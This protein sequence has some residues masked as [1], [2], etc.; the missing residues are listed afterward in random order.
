[1]ISKTFI[2]RKNTTIVIAIIIV[3]VGLICM[4][5][6]PIAQL[7][8]IAPPVT[9]VRANYVGANS[10]TVEETVTT[11][12]EN[13]VNGTPGA[14]YIQSVSANDGSMSITVSFKLGTNPDIATL[15]V[16]NRVSLALPSTPDEV[17][18]VGV[19]VKKRSN[20]ML[21]VIAL[22]SPKGKHSR[23][24]LDNYM[25]IYL[26]PELARVSGVG[27]VNAFSQDYSMRIWLNPDKMAALGLTAGDIAR[28]ITEQNQQVPAGSVGAAPMRSTQAFEYT[29]SVKGRLATTEEFGNVVV[30]T[31]QNGSLVRLRDV[32]RIDLG[33]FTYAIEAKA[34]GKTG[35]GMAIY[36]APGANALDVND[37]V[38]AKLEEMSKR[39][40][41]DVK[42][43]VPFESTS[44]VK[45]SIEEV[46]ETFVEALI[47]VVIVVFVFLQ[48]WRATIIPILVIPISLIGTFI[49]FQLLGF[50]INTLTLF[51]FVLAIG[52]VVDDAI[53]VVEAVQHH[54]DANLMTPREATFKAMSEV[55]GPVIAIALIL[56]AVFVPVAFIP[57]VSGRLYQQFALTIAFS[58]LLSA[59][60]ALTL[61][62]ALT[63]ILLR[64]AHLTQ[65]ST[66]LNKIFFKFNEWFARVT[67]RYG[68]GVMFSIRKT[69]AV[70]VIMAVLFVAAFYLFKKTPT[71]FVPQEDMGA[72]FIALELPEASSSQRTKEVVAQIS[73][74][75]LKDSAVLHFFGITGIN[76]V[77]NATKPNSGTFFVSLR[78]W[79]ER[80]KH[81]DNMGTVL[82]R[83]QM[84][85]SRIVGANIICIPSPTLRGLGNTGGFSFMLEQRSNPDINQFLQVMGQFLMA[86]N[87]R[88]EIARAYAFF[89]ANTPQFNVEVD[90]DKCKQLGV[91]V[92]DVFNALQT[93]LGGLYVNDFTKFSRSFRVVLQADSTYRTS[94]NNLNTYYVR[95]ATGQM[96]P[97]SALITTKKASG[98]PVINH[99]NLYRSVEINGDTKPGYSSGD[100]INALK[101]VAAQVLPENFSFEWA[102]VSLQEIEAGNSSVLIFGLSILF[103]FLLLTALY[104]SWS[105]PFSVLLAVPIALFGSILALSLT[106]QSNSV[107]SQIGLITLIGLAA[108]N[109]IL[110]VEFCKE[111]VDRGMPLLDATLEAVKLRL[112]PILMT[113]FAFILGVLPLCLA[114]GA[115]AASRVNIGFTVVGGMLA[116]TLLGIFTVPVLYVLITKL[117]YG[118]KKLADLEA[119]GNEEKKPKGL[120]E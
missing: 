56:A 117:S 67:N 24:F 52:I 13:Q 25:N 85:T 105:V 28:A 101:E 43:L 109:A 11:P 40:P 89:S 60:L 12:I 6:L 93:F 61:T 75:L 47:L 71:T 80:Y 68:K 78:P 102:N 34:D 20:D 88:P 115:G 32:A 106:K 91:A 54:I 18:R 94:I 59:F 81:G 116:A 62:P 35:S 38:I 76:F 97:L 70:L 73:D 72:M 10:T 99:F 82:G 74:I 27:D 98:A 79:D 45:I 19:T 9:D 100:G 37:L 5:N 65:K 96:V 53:V 95:N 29:V 87:Q 42:W 16:Q 104:E 84:A 33:S 30:A 49:F 58:V 118:K 110:I 112:R 21:M 120:G 92:S 86:A 41:E 57:G 111:R 48:N 119:H 107:Y 44:F 69:P 55:Q 77:A 50:S 113:S 31:S 103:V 66:G 108:K 4:F 2:E 36:L 8:D 90:R 51:G 26:K 46:I 39:F 63:A 14:M 23:E 22:N 1:M 64:P 7:P 114:Q 17:R 83:I 15:D 3:I